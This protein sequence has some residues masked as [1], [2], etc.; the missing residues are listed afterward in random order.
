MPVLSSFSNSAASSFGQRSGKPLVAEYL[1]IGGGGGGAIGGGGGGGY[2]TGTLSVSN[3]TSYTVTVGTGGIGIANAPSGPAGAGGNSVFASLT[4]IGGGGG[5]NGYGPGVWTNGGSGGS[6]GGGHY[7]GTAGAATSGQGNAGGPGNSKPNTG[8]GGGGA[9]GVGGTPGDSNGGNGG[10]GLSSSIT[11]IAVSRAGGGGGY[12][13]GSATAGGGNAN[14]SGTANTGGGAGA[15]AGGGSNGG[16]GVVILAYPNT[17]NN[18]VV[19]GTLD[20]VTDTT[21][22]AGYKVYTFRS[23]TGTVTHSPTVNGVANIQEALNTHTGRAGLIGQV[24]GGDWRSTIATG[25][26]GSLPLSSPTTYTSINYG[27]F[28]DYYGFIAI[29]YFKPPTTGTYTFFTSSDDGS[30]V[31]IGDIAAASS[32]RNTGNA[33]LNNNMGGGQGNTKRSGST[34]LTAG[35]WYPIRI[36]HEE[37]VGGDNLTFS[38]SGP[39]IGETTS[40]STYFKAPMT[41]TGSNLNTYFS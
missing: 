25:N 29:G 22:R 4:A 17:F 16:S 26:I 30:G 27:S 12:N 20:Y 23:G 39:G 31:W 11:G 1:V 28:S 3:G 15:N 7:L 33:V 34:T 41:L 40:L 8:A 36:V 14:S 19:D 18:L 38:W 32:G 13:N 5:G 9:G 10:A 35:I 37:V 6:G 24:F 2:L 21:S